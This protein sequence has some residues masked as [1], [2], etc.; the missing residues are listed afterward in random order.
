MAFSIYLA[1]LNNFAMDSLM[2]LH[3]AIFGPPLLPFESCE[4]VLGKNT[5]LHEKEKMRYFE[6]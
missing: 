3:T 6:N 5:S 4:V 1:E 2:F